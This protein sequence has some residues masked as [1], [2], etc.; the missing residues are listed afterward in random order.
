MCISNRLLA[1][2]IDVV[3]RIPIRIQVLVQARRG[4]QIRLCRIFRQEAA[5]LGVVES[6]L[7]VERHGPPQIRLK[8]LSFLDVK[9]KIAG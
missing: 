3:C 5:D 1:I 7:C 2:R 9:L 8:R 6:G 4:G